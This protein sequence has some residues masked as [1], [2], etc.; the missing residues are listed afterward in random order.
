MSIMKTSYSK[1]FLTIIVFLL[2][3][4]DA[5]C[6][7]YSGTVS[8]GAITWEV[9]DETGVLSLSGEGEIVIPGSYNTNNPWSK[10]INSIREVVVGE[11]VSF[12]KNFRTQCTNATTVTINSN[13]VFSSPVTWSDERSYFKGIFGDQVKKYIIGEGVK[14]IASRK[15]FECTGLEEIYLPTSLDSIGASAFY[16]CMN[17]NAVH[18]TDLDRWL[19]IG[20]EPGQKSNPV[21]ASGHGHLYLNGEEVTK[22]KFPEGVTS[23]AT[24][25]FEN[26][27][28]LEAV[29]FPKSLK[30]IGYGAFAECTNLSSIDIPEGVTIIE[31]YVFYGCSNLTSV[32]LPE[33]V[34]SI[35]PYA[36]A[37][38]AEEVSDGIPSLSLPSTLKTIGEYSFIYSNIKSLTIPEGA[39][40]IAD[41][42]FESSRMVFISIPSTMRTI[43]VDAFKDC[44]SLQRVDYASIESLCYIKFGNDLSNPLNLACHLYVKGN[45]VK[46]VLIPQ[47][48][49][50]IP[51]YSF[52]GA[53][54]NSV[55]LPDGL[56]EIGVG[57]FSFSTL[58]S[59][60]IPESVQNIGK[61]AFEGSAISNIDLSHYMGNIGYY[62]FNNC[63]VLERVTLPAENP[64][65]YTSEDGKVIFSRDS[66]KFRF[67]YYDDETYNYYIRDSI[68]YE[69]TLVSVLPTVKELII[70]YPVSGGIPANRDGVDTYNGMLCI[71]SALYGVFK[72]LRRLELPCSWNV[73]LGKYKYL[74]MPNLEELVLRSPKP[75]PFGTKVYW[76]G[77][78]ESTVP[79]IYDEN[80]DV[81]PFGSTPPK[82]YVYEYAR[83]E[84]E[85][86]SKSENYDW[87]YNP[88][89]G[90]SS[91]Y[92]S[93]SLYGMKFETL[94]LPSDQMYVQEVL[95]LY[96]KE[97]TI[98]RKIGEDSY[99]LW[100]CDWNNALM[101][102]LPD[103]F[104]SDLV[105]KGN[106]IP[107]EYRFGMVKRYLTEE[108]ML[109]MTG[110]VLQCIDGS[111][112]VL[113]DFDANDYLN[114]YFLTDILFAGEGTVTNGKIYAVKS[115]T[116]WN[117]P[118]DT[119]YYVAPSGP[120]ANANL[121]YD[122]KMLPGIVYNLYLLVAPHLS[123]DGQGYDE[124]YDILINRIRPQL[125]SWIDTGYT[126]TNGTDIDFTYTG[127][128]QTHLLF[129][130]M[131]VQKDHINTL[132]INSKITS[133]LLR[134]GY[135]N[136]L[137]LLGVMAIPQ[138]TPDGISNAKSLINQT[139]CFYDLQG[140][141]LSAPQRG[142]N[143]I[144]M[145][146]G[147]TRKVLVK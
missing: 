42:A 28:A 33:R 101:T 123:Y 86:V 10:Y 11:G 127:E 19:Q 31:P 3:K 88:T 143:I 138:N 26:W 135:T 110:D 104:T 65:R 74:L 23:V 114:W 91:I 93:Q 106:L 38:I 126:L 96:R 56:E 39:D 140:R 73:G 4:V 119:Y 109:S 12:G 100:D 128:V 77:K 5:Q 13:S 17:L 99:Y 59:I 35:E 141:K 27:K 60:N 142:I 112:H 139:T 125:R 94:E 21:C 37:H 61:S 8:S 71:E 82:I 87:V 131:E 92:Y 18:I 47:T 6:E 136:N 64:Y 32:R 54:I 108:K 121:T 34:T 102:N 29:T 7:V 122:I 107:E 137:A 95:P 24:F 84:Y 144:R 78:K 20:Y 116:E 58:H 45:E 118:N 145:S 90:L 117:I 97:Y 43:G 62:A 9:N 30:E 53:D 72:D 115:P 70:P 111:V 50:H 25:Q 36:F 132:T 105:T 52:I 103:Y 14:K 2:T 44:I 124:Q 40:S 146:D 76:N 49:T 55:Q 85:K 130:N 134:N 89:Y 75:T 51:Q 129:E 46:D 66:I 133:S 120:T 98:E 80:G 113:S 57:A 69:P 48:V 1:I 16:Y 22:I 147:T 63:Q 81:I 41:K 67:E 83:N 15:F 68:H 79:I